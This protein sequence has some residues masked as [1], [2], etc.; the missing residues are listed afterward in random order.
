MGMDSWKFLGDP[1]YDSSNEKNENFEDLGRPILDEISQDVVQSCLITI[2]NNKGIHMG[3]S[4]AD[5]EQLSSHSHIVDFCQHSW[6]CFLGTNA[7]FGQQEAAGKFWTM[8]FNGIKF[9]LGMRAC[10][11]LNSEAGH[12][13][14][15][16]VI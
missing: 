15:F 6:P 12:A 14:H 1:T 5:V 8:N 13:S 16:F 11:A 2:D 7:S 4:V 3:I 9:Q 10:V